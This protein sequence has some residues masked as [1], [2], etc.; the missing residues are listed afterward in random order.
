MA[1]RRRHL[2]AD[3]AQRRGGVDRL[4]TVRRVVVIGDHDEV[5]PRVAGGGC[6]RIRSDRAVAVNGVQMESAA[7]PRRRT[8]RDGG[9]WQPSSFPE[10]TEVAGKDGCGGL[11]LD[12]DVEA[13]GRDTVQAEQY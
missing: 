1:G 5:E 13:C 6:Q 11:D 4:E 8:N 7:E 10:R 9:G 12:V 2:L 3:D